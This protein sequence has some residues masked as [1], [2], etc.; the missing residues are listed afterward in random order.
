MVSYSPMETT[1]HCLLPNLEQSN[2]VC[3][4]GYSFYLLWKFMDEFILRYVNGMCGIGRIY[5]VAC[6]V[7]TEKGTS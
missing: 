7:E 5:A 1:E 6:R 4:P 3:Q 2:A